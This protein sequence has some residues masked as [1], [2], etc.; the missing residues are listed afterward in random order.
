MILLWFTCLSCTGEE[1]FSFSVKADVVSEET[2]EESEEPV[3]YSSLPNTCA[4]SQV[5]SDPLIEK[6]FVFT[7]DYVFAELLDIVYEPEEEV[8]WSVGQGGLMV[9]DV[10]N[11]A[12]PEFMTSY[13]PLAWHERAYHLALDGSERIFLTHRK[14]GWMSYDI[15][16]PLQAS[17]GEFMPLSGA[18]GIAYEEDIVY[19][20]THTGSVYSYDV[21]LAFPEM[22]DVVSDLGNPWRMVLGENY[23]Y[24]ADNTQGLVVINRQSPQQLTVKNR[25]LGSGGLQDVVLNEEIAYGAAGGLGIDVFDVSNPESPQWIGN[26]PT[27]YPAIELA[28]DNDVLWVASQQDVIAIDISNPYDPV[29]VNTEKTRQ[30]AMAIDA[31]DGYAFVADWGYLSILELQADVSGSDLHLASNQVYIDEN[32]S[33]LIALRNF[34]TKPIEIFGGTSSHPDVGLEISSLEIEPHETQWL[35]IQKNTSQ[36]SQ[37]CIASSDPDAS[38]EYINVVGPQEHPIGSTAP[39]FSLTSLD[40]TL[41]RLQEM[42]GSYVVLVYFATW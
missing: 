14:N 27:S 2:Q 29:I 40:G 31:A 37:I 7:Q 1:H 26:I 17:A 3:T 24:V 9:F 10:S 19:V 38:Q 20:A 28:V 22:L 21:S 34:G 36:G 15:R 6:G 4:P 32:E 13:S 42:Y 35:S 30:W 25:V 5:D 18:S 12:Q 23:V 33:M 11:P 41:Y 8:I 16:N 39:D